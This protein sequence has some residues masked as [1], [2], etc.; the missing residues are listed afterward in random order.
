LLLPLFRSASQGRILAA[1]YLSDH[2]KS[3]ADLAEELSLPYA[4]AHREVAQLLGA[5]LL[6]EN[7]VGNSRLVGPNH[8]SPYFPPLHQLLE[9]AFGPVPLLR[10]EFE[11]IDGISGSVIFGSWAHR[12]LG[13]QGAPPADIDVLVVGTPDVALV[14]A[15]CSKVGLIVGRP[16]NATILT[17]EEW[18]EATPFLEEVRRGGMLAVTGTLGDS[19]VT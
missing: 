7:R 17:E 16:V 13:Q 6:A 14:Y 19:E 1:L 12:A 5:G 11:A 10:A 9:L 15:A 3:I 4:T 18:N 8:D 2:E